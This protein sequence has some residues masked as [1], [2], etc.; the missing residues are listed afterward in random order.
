MRNALLILSVISL[1]ST[2]CLASATASDSSVP[3]QTSVYAPPLSARGDF[4]VAGDQQLLPVHGSDL[5]LSSAN[6]TSGTSA[7]SPQVS[8]VEAIPTP[9]AFHA[10][11]LLLVIIFAGRYF[12]KLRFN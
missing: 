7:S 4:S 12:R 2:A 11:G 1:I 9:T 8:V 5:P 6:G 3:G 10:G